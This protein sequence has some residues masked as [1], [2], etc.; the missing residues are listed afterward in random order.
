MKLY[1]ENCK[2]E[3]FLTSQWANSKQ[4]KILLSFERVILLKQVQTRDNNNQTKIAVT[5]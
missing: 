5:I 1:L 2:F 3:Y 4:I